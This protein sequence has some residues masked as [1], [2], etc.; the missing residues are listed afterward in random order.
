METAVYTYPH[1]T[2]IVFTEE[3]EHGNSTTM[4][5]IDR[6]N[7]SV[8]DKGD[9]AL[10]IGEEGSQAL[11]DCS[12]YERAITEYSEWT[13]YCAKKIGDKVPKGSREI[14]AIEDLLKKAVEGRAAIRK[15]PPT[16]DGYCSDRISRY[17]FWGIKFN[18]PLS[19]STKQVEGQ[20]L[21]SLSADPFEHPEEMDPAR[22][23]LGFGL[24]KIKISGVEVSAELYINNDELDPLSDV[25]NALNRRFGVFNDEGKMD[26]VYSIDRVQFFHVDLPRP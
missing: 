23:A 3:P 12:Y 26:S 7:N 21:L 5:I 6:N 16:A 17:S 9:I 14:K 11:G 13:K 8:L 2:I 22:C 10:I 15:A 24:I 19:L 25:N 18:P 20:P 4:A 1:Q